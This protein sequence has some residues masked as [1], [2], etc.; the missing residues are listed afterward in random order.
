M[1]LRKCNITIID[2]LEVTLDRI[3]LLVIPFP[4]FLSS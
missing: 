1:L 4:E 2:V 3:S